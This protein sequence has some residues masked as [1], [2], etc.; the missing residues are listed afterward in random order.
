MPE[1]P[2]VETIAR[3]LRPEIVGREIRGA[4]LLW[5]RTLATPSRRKFVSQVVGQRIADVSRRGKF[6]RLAL[7]PERLELLIHL[8]MSGDLRLEPGEY[9]PETHDRL[10]LAL[11]G[12]SSLV[13][14]DTRKFGRVW[15]TAHPEQVTGS[16]GPEPLS[17]DF[18]V[19]W[20]AA[21]LRRRRRQLKPLLLDQTF[22]AGLGNIYTDESL[23]MAR[24]HPVRISDSIT[25]EEAGRLWESIRETLRKGL[26]LNG[27]SIDWVYRGGGYQTHFRVY[28]REGK[29]CP[30]CGTPIERILVGQ[31]STHF[32]PNCQPGGGLRPERTTY[33]APNAHPPERRVP[34]GRRKYAAGARPAAQPREGQR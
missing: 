32:C 23:H 18:T 16:L 28:D 25:D 29:P 14:N 31:R 3:G 9:T 10:I 26:E 15:L 17:E 33:T 21:A 7:E 11:S 13:F 8:R 27:A 1:L 2:E 20:L 19:A 30:V 34:E 12:G 24:L 22:L 6:L 4:K 5:S